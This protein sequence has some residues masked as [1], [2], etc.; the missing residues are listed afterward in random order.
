MWMIS[1]QW[2]LRQYQKSTFERPLPPPIPMKI[3]DEVVVNAKHNESGLTGIASE[4]HL[5]AGC[6]L[7]VAG[8]VGATTGHL[9]LPY[10]L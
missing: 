2:D 10:P 9:A 7:L 8:R 3:L 1:F 6:W 5:V 4:L